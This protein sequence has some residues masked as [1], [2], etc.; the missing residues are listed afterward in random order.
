MNKNQIYQRNIARSLQELY[1]H[2]SNNL[3]GWLPEDE[4]IRDDQFT[5]E[6]EDSILAVMAIEEEW[7]L[8]EQA[9][10]ECSLISW[11]FE[12]DD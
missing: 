2:M 4:H 7:I 3:L 10:E 12:D 9:R 1:I 5:P 6:Q 11:I 8:D